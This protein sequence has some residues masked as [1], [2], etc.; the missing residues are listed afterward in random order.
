[1]ADVKISGLPVATTPLAGTEEVPLVQSGV[2]KKTTINSIVSKVGAVTA[3]T[4]TAPVVSSGGTTPAI[5]MPAATTSVNGYLTSTDWNTFNNKQPAGSYLTNGGP[6]GTP[7]S[8][9]LTN[10]TGLPISTGVSGLGTGVATFL[11]TPS[12]ANLAAAVTGETGTGSLVFATSPTLVTPILGTP[13]SAT[14]TNAT[15]LPLTT[16][17]TGT[18]PVVNGGTGTSTPALVAGTNVTITGTWPNQTINSSGGG[19]GSGTVTSA[20]VVSANGL[21]GTVANPTTTPAITLSTTVT[22]VVKGNGT[23]LSAATAGTDYVAPGGALGTPSSGTATNLTGLPLTTGVTGVLPIANGGTNASTAANARTNILPSYTGNAGK[24]LAVNA[25]ATDVEYIA[26][27]GTGTVT[28]V[29]TGTGLTGGPITA[30]G[31]IALANTAVTAGAYTSANITVDAQGRITAAANGS[32]GASFQVGEVMLA[33]TAPSTGTW[34]ETGKY[35]SKAAYPTLSTAIGSVADFG[36]PVIVPQAQLPQSFQPANTARLSLYGV[37]TNGTITVAVGT[38]ASQGA[39][40]TTTDGTTWSGVPSQTL[41]TFQEVRYLNGNFIAVANSGSTIVTSTDG[42][43]WVARGN[44]VTNGVTSVAFGN[45][46]YVCVCSTNIIQYSS[47]LINWTSVTLTGITNFTRVVYANS[48]FVAVGSS[49]IFTSTDGITWTNRSVTASF[50]DVFYANSL[51]VA[52]GGSAIYTST[53][54]ITWTLRFSTGTYY[55]VTYGNSLYVAVG[56]SG[57]LATSSDGITWTDRQI[58]NFTNINAVIWNGTSFY[59]VAESG[60]FATS[61]NGT[62]WTPNLD[63]SCANFFTIGVVSGKTIAFGEASSVILAGATRAEVMQSSGW[64]FANSPLSALNPRMIAYN[65]SNLYVHATGVGRILTSPDGQL[66]TGRYSGTVLNFDKVQYVN[67]NFVALG[68]GVV[69]V[70]SNGTTWTIPSPSI[71]GSIGNAIAFGAGVYVIAGTS[72]GVYSS[73]DL[74]TWTSR[75]AGSQDFFDVIFANSIFV[76]VGNNGACY[77]STDGITWTSRTAGAS[78]FNRII[79]ANSLFVAIATNANIYTSS[80]GLTWTQRTFSGSTSSLLDVVWNGSQFCTVGSG[81]TIGTSPDGITWTT[82]TPGDTTLALTSISWNG[83]RFVVTNTT[84]GVVWHSTDGI[85]WNRASTITNRETSYSGYLGGKF[86]A[87]GFSFIQTSADGI[88]WTASDNVQYVPTS[89]NKVYKLGAYYYALT[90]RGMFQS[91]DGISFTISSRNITCN[92][93]TSMAYSGSVW[94]AIAPAISGQPQATY[95][96]SNGTTWT[97]VNDFG[98]RTTTSTIATGFVDV[99]YAGGN[100]IFGTSITVVQ[101]VNNTIYTS[102]NGVS[103]TGR[104]VPFLALPVTAMGSDGT[105][106]VFSSSVGSFKS[107]NAGV[108]WI[109]FTANQSAPIIYSNGVWII[110]TTVNHVVSPDLSNFY[111]T[112]ISGSSQVPTSV[113]VSGNYISALNNQNRIYFNKTASG[114]VA[115]PV[116]ASVLLGSTNTNKEIPIRGTTALTTV[117][118]SFVTHPNLIAETPLYSYDTATTFWIPPSNAGAGQQAYIYAGA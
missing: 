82:R 37:A 69:G 90:N 107:S 22:G 9:T 10:T 36:T 68:N 101:G 84:N 72:G 118:Q 27:G 59:A 87:V 39:I 54:G 57:A 105:N 74:V 48:I 108:T 18:L 100:F 23:A 81:G 103:W 8:G 40:R 88:N 52:V 92:P 112:G 6:L 5:S 109:S 99:V 26:V 89:I 41:G 16:G 32:G 56:A 106:V 25:G 77:S 114:Y 117:S 34:L 49:N 64:R 3:V 78:S 86:I 55:S 13:T 14:L 76:A 95:T 65:G 73:P 21:A 115:L 62:S 7:S 51:F 1:M 91:S 15:G 102:T 45:G 35:Y 58:T 71:G 96:S 61:A 110:N 4:G 53:D 47:D 50:N 63:S 75:S 33:T 17:V 85:T 38:A 98:T 80:D 19:G 79:Y 24:V 94:L 97:K 42:T 29:G 44:A 93:I 46:M 67:G 2:T 12:S 20:S 66:W 28:S 113:Y 111:S 31:T 70:S 104:Q 30:S 116:I 83:T 11:A 43:N 60:Y